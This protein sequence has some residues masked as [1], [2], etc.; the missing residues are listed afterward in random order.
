MSV[1]VYYYSLYDLSAEA[2]QWRR[3]MANQ[4]QTDDHENNSG[5]DVL[6]IRQ[7]HTKLRNKW[8]FIPDYWDD[9]MVGKHREAV[10]TANKLLDDDLQKIN[11]T[12]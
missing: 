6:N 8:R 1:P 9:D 10:W 12:R 11:A 3:D 4:Q 7:S 2:R 5:I